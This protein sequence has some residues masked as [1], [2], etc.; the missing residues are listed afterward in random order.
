MAMTHKDCT[1]CGRTR[2]HNST[3]AKYTANGGQWRC[4][5]CGYPPTSNTN[6]GRKE[7][8]EQKMRRLAG[9]LI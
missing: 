7:L 4:T 1:Y 6:G 5:A 3:S 9:R 2:W 8:A